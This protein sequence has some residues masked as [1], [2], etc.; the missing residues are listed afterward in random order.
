MEQW[1]KQNYG[2]IMLKQDFKDRAYHTPH[3]EE[4]GYFYFN[5]IE[6]LFE[7]RIRLLQVAQNLLKANHSSATL[8]VSLLSEWAK[9]RLSQQGQLPQPALVSLMK[10]NLE[11]SCLS[12]DLVWQQVDEEFWAKVDTSAHL[13]RHRYQH[14]K[15][16]RM[17]LQLPLFTSVQSSLVAQAR[18]MMNQRTHEELTAELKAQNEALEEHKLNLERSVL[19]RTSELEIAKLKAEEATQAK[20]MFLANMSHEIRTP[21]NAIIGLSHLALEQPL[22]PIQRDYVQK[23]NHA[24]RS[25]LT[26]I[27]DILDFS[28]I[29]AGELKFET[30]SFQLDELLQ[31]LAVMNGGA[32]TDKQIELTI[33]VASDVP[34]TLESD[35]LRLKQVITN[36]LNNAIKFTS[37]GSVSL[38]IERADHAQVESPY[39]LLFTVQDTGIGMSPVQL[40][41]LFKPFSQADESTTRLFGGTGLGLSICQRLVSMMKGKIWV[42]SKENVGSNFY[43]TLPQPKHLFT[44][45]ENLQSPLIDL[46]QDRVLIVE[47]SEPAREAL[48]LHLSRLSPQIT[49]ATNASEARACFTEAQKLGLPFKW[50]LVDWKLPD[51]SG[52]ELLKEWSHLGEHFI[53]FITAY[54]DSELSERAKALGAHLVLQKPLTASTLIDCMS[55]LWLGSHPSKIVEHYT[56]VPLEQQVRSLEGMHVLLVDDHEVNRLIA[57]QLLKAVGIRVT[58]AYHGLMALERALQDQPELILMDIQM[59]IMDGYTATRKL[60]EAGF[61][62]PIL[63]MTAHAM[64]EERTRCLQAGMDDHITKPISPHILYKTLQEWRSTERTESEHQSH[65]IAL[66]DPMIE[67]EGLMDQNLQHHFLNDTLAG[68]SKE[69]FNQNLALKLTGGKQDL[70]ITLLIKFLPTIQSIFDAHHTH[71][72]LERLAHT[73]KGTGAQL[74]LIYLSQE[75]TRLEDVLRQNQEEQIWKPILENLRGVARETLTKLEHMGAQAPHSGTDLPLENHLPI[76]EHEF[77][78]LKALQVLCEGFDINAQQMASELDDQVKKLLKQQ[79]TT[80]MQAMSSFEFEACAKL[81]KQALDFYDDQ[82]LV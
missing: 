45:H 26:I 55:E 76:T 72:S 33:Q 38:K 58:E 66:L 42:T 16:T 21:M 17:L 74:G 9:F 80:F 53:L 36:L 82:N 11:V 51:G 8:W 13:K 48:R 63:A 65:S 79:V 3:D 29:E 27:N 44:Q 60:R 75:A 20:S 47:D 5:P 43:F 57:H 4:L 18:T 35:D 25:L 61:T 64:A 28:K 81:L 7:S 62:R 34:L 46:S 19:E 24:G 40:N 54:G 12:I 30:R 71:E 68:N 56:P 41:K 10:S 6:A 37:H 49:E 50:L 77:V 15:H 2:S 23:I 22:A 73:L 52:L 39:S 59:P 32:A 14:L 31:D 78:Q 1:S 67:D 70:L 69:I